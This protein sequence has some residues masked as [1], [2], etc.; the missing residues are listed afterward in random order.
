MQLKPTLALRQKRL[1]AV[2][3]ELRQ[4]IGLMQMGAVD[5]RRFIHQQCAENPL[6]KISGQEDDKGRKT[7]PSHDRAKGALDR[8]KGTPRTDQGMPG[9]LDQ[10]SAKPGL[11]EHVAGQLGYCGLTAAEMPAALCFVE[12][13]EP[14]GW[15][16]TG[17]EQVAAQTGLSPSNCETVLKKIQKIEPTGFF[18][19]DLSECLRL[20]LEEIGALDETM[21]VLLENL[22]GLTELGPDRFA[23]KYK[24]RP[25]RVLQKLAEIRTLDPKPGSGF[26][27]ERSSVIVPDLIAEKRS[28]RW[29]VELNGSAL[30]TIEVD[31]E[32][33]RQLSSTESSEDE[34]EAFRKLFGSARWVL[35]AIRRRQETLL[36]VGTELIRHQSAFLEDGPAALR[37]L[38]QKDI[39]EKVGISESTVSRVSNAAYIQTPLATFPLKRFFSRGMPVSDRHENWSAA[40]I[41][42]KIKDIVAIEDPKHPFSDSQIAERLNKAGVE[43]A[44]RTVA[45]YRGV[46]GVPGKAKRR[47]QVAM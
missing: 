4:A 39:A 8:A 47:L 21:L 33:S 31:A 46:A 24:L 23:A 20:Q 42:S 34:T 19:R 41:Q 35:H 16:G 22:S 12:S 6:L 27:A 26:S 11:F 29:F 2:T 43:I 10:V 28:G 3:P 32:L 15:L 38:L 18:A 1:L 7:A 37:P 17:I 13:L 14:S 5:V 30:P 45:K 36:K 40:Q 44:R 25:E 9:W